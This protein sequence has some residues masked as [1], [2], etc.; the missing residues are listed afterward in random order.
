[1]RG[2]VV[3]CKEHNAPF[4]IEEYAVPEL[5]PGAIL[6]R[7]VQSG[8]CGSDLHYWRGRPGQRA[9]AADGAGDG[10][11]GV[12]GGAQPG[13]GGDAGLARQAAAG[14][15]PGGVY[16]D[17]PVQPVSFVPEG[18]WEP[19]RES[20]VSGGGRLSVLYGHVRGLFVPT[21]G[22][23]NF[24]GAGRH[25]GRGAGAGELRHGD[26]DAGADFGGGG[27]GGLGGDSGSGRAGPDGDGGGEGYGGRTG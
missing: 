6:L 17:I 18:I 24:P 8:I 2:R 13:E 25:F 5:E 26:G 14:G 3:V 12:R 11:R 19:V 7:M 22:T 20:S 15:G 27:S 9:A 21:A 1:M 16:G 4:E 10:A 23:P